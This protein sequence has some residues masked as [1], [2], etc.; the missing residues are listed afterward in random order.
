M[1]ARHAPVRTPSADDP[2]VHLLLF[3]W[4]GTRRSL[5]KDAVKGEFDLV[6]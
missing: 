2:R 4:L 5:I 3:L 6:A 1:T